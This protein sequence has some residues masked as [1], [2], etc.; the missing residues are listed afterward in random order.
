MGFRKNH[1]GGIWCRWRIAAVFPV[2]LLAGCGFQPLYKEQSSGTS[3]SDELKRIYVAGIPDRDGQMFRLALQQHMAGAGP[4]EPD[5]YVLRANLSIGQEAIDIHSDNTSG[6]TRMNGAAHWELY[7]VAEH[8]QFVAS[9]DAATMDGMEVTYQ[10]M[11]A[12]SMNTETVHARV[13]ETLAAEV[14]QQVAIWFRNHTQ[15][16]VAPKETPTYYP[17]SDAIPDSNNQQPVEA[18]GPDGMPAMATGRGGES[19]GSGFDNNNN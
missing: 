19:S 7:T 5:G 15:A 14:T 13:A 1:A 3:V 6:R 12:Q 16:P 11:F 9:G 4:E 18:A 8:P 17:R 10:Q 2:L